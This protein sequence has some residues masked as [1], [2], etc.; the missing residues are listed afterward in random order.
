MYTVSSI[1][2]FD[3]L[4]DTDMGVIKYIQFSKEYQRSGNFH[5]GLMEATS[6]ELNKLIQNLLVNRK[7]ANPISIIMKPEKMIT[8]NPDKLL[9]SLMKDEKIYDKIL[10]L[11]TPTAIFDMVCRSFFVSDTLKYTILCSS[12][13]EAKFLKTKF[14]S[15][16]KTDKVPATILVSTPDKVDLKHIDAIYVKDVHD[17]DKYFEKRRLPSG[18]NIIIADYTFNNEYVPE[19][20]EYLHIPILEISSKYSGTN[21]IS[22]INVYPIDVYEDDDNLIVG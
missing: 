13:K 16:F 17:I 14:N 19:Q 22:F 7:F 18:K 1:V 4:I 5:R 10:K 9:E 2:P 3:L 21:E 11:S 20:D 6:P 15:R 12:D 8:S